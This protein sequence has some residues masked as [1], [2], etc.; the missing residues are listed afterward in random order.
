MFRFVSQKLHTVQR[1]VE[2]Q[3]A[4]PASVL[5]LNLPD[6]WHVT[7]QIAVAYHTMFSSIAYAAAAVSLPPR[8]L[9]MVIVFSH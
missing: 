5:W 4:V 1:E 7:L 2:R 3:T 6:W 8:D 9:S